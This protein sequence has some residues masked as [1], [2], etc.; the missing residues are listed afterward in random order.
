[1]PDRNDSTIHPAPRPSDIEEALPG[2]A[3]PRQWSGD[4]TPPPTPTPETRPK[5]RRRDATRTTPAGGSRRR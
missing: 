4:G 1:M 2:A 5:R 3:L